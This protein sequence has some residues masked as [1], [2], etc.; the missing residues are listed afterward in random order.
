LAR[1][2]T[3]QITRRWRA[4]DVYAPHDLSPVEMM[5]WRKRGKPQTDVFDVLE[6]DPLVEWKVC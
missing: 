6:L 2:L 1:D 4:G 3:K 5:K